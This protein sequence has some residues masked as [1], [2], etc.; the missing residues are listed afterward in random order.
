MA[1]VGPTASSSGASVSA[2]GP[3]TALAS[4]ASTSGSLAFTWSPPTTGGAASSYVVQYRVS[5]TPTW[6][7][8][9]ANPVSPSITLT[10]LSPATSYDVEVGA[11]NSGGTSSYVQLLGVSTSTTLTVPG[12]PLAL[13]TG[14]V[15][16]SSVSLTWTAAGSGGTPTG[17]MVEYS[18]D[19]GSTWSQPV[20]FGSATSCTVTGLSAATTYAFRVAATNAA[21][22]SP[23]VPTS[24]FPTAMTA[25]VS[26]APGLP[27]ALTFTAVSSS[28]MTVQWTAPS[29]TV[30][31][32]NLQYRVLNTA[33]WIVISSAITS[34][35]ISGLTPSTT[36]EF[37]VQSVSGAMTSQ[38]TSSVTNATATGSTG[39]YKL[40]PAPTRQSPTTG[41]VGTTIVMAN[42]QPSSGYNVGDN[43]AAIDGS[44]PV[45]AAV[46]FAWS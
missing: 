5:G 22:S 18:L 44:N 25:A 16:T 34:A 10:G 12:S 15:T 1:S 29:G 14:A 36:Y 33:T 37:Q 28:S 41:W 42:G 39:I 31:G 2:P 26:T 17:Y 46:G 38:Y 8:V 7:P 40:T 19:G 23:Y 9:S 20:S 43:S 27:T 30:T 4:A 21:G 35:T 6:T 13:A 24:A 32:Y 45:P 3:I 11:S